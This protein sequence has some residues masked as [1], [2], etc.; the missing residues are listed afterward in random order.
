MV[1]LEA[2]S[3]Q[4]LPVDKLLLTR[5]TEDQL[6]DLAGNAMST[7]VVGA[8]IL[9]ALV[10][11]KK[12]LKAGNES[13]TY[14]DRN[15]KLSPEKE[16]DSMDIDVHPVEQPSESR[17]VGEERL[18]KKSLDL[19]IVQSCSY[20][21]LLADA[22]KSKRLCPCEG[23]MD[24]TSRPVF[25]CQD[26]GS[27][28]CQKCGGRPEHNPL[29]FDIFKQP[30]AHPSEFAKKL[31]ATL[32][33]C[34]TLEAVDQ[35]L[36]DR[37]RKHESVNIPDSIWSKWRTAVILASNSEF[38]F[39]ELKRQETW[40][41]VYQSAVGVL[42]LYLYPHQPEWRLFA[43]ADVNEPA[44]ADI[45]QV[46]QSPVG[47]FICKGD[48]LKGSWNFALPCSTTVSLKIQG[49]SELVPSWEARL[50]L[51]GEEFKN[52][53]VYSKVKVS[54]NESDIAKIDR[55][56]SGVYVLL[57]KCGTANGALHKKIHGDPSDIPVFML[58]DPHRTNDSEDCFVFTSDIRRL[59][60]QECRP[61]IC[62]VDPS[63][64]QSCK[65]GEQ[66][67]A[68]SL[69]FTWTTVDSVKLKVGPFFTFEQ[70]TNTTQAF[71]WA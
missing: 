34:I 15:G 28:S 69:P 59:E 41:V 62:K 4:G 11:G 61:I 12:L 10:T 65:D 54:L 51:V 42:E 16:T 66:T 67:V 3:M 9:A 17:V 45:R 57:D 6:A 23:R 63:W 70:L 14:E 25:T 33:M 2:L 8:C 7:T 53:M 49:L 40:S 44:N 5:E 48:L 20:S 60:Y 32:P 31:K 71:Y 26:C 46:L 21:E 47:R 52:K 50:G 64:R 27:S 37:L 22:E 38:R 1:G 39:V 58:F 56:I 35:L 55:D 36:L 29:P 18:Q 13:Q 30:R 24:I 19:S 68:G 43:F